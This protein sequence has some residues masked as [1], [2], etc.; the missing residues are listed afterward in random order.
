MV[1]PF[2]VTFH[3]SHSSDCRKMA[4]YM[5]RHSSVSLLSQGILKLSGLGFPIIPVVVVVVVVIVVV[6]NGVYLDHYSRY[7]D[8][9]W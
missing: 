6:N 1:K 4:E 8:E 5:V 7:L 2:Y 3:R 9:T